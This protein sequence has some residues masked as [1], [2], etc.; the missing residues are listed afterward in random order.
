MIQAA[1]MLS[2]YTLMLCPLNSFF[3]NK[4][5]HADEKLDCVMPDML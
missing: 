2:S 3:I 5:G 4:L 1:I